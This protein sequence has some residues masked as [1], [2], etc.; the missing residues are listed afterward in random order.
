MSPLGKGIA[1]ASIFKCMNP[2]RRFLKDLLKGTLS[3]A[4]L[5]GLGSS[6]ATASKASAAPLCSR[7][8]DLSAKALGGRNA[9]YLHSSL[10]GQDLPDQLRAWT[11]KDYVLREKDPAQKRTI[12]LE[13]FL[14]RDLIIAPGHR[15]L[16]VSSSHPSA[17]PA[18][19]SQRVLLNAIT[20][21][22]GHL[23]FLDIW[24][25][26]HRILEA[27]RQGAET[28]KSLQEQGFIVDILIN[29]KPAGSF[30]AWKHILPA[31]A[32][33]PSWE[34]RAR[35]LS[36]KDV[37][38]SGEWSN[39]ELGSRTTLSQLVENEAQARQTK[40]G[41]F[42]GTFDPV[43]EN[44]IA[45]AKMGLSEFGL[46]KVILIPNALPQ[47]KKP[48]LL[49]YRQALLIERIKN[50]PG[51]DT[52]LFDTHYF[53]ERFGKHTLVEKIRQDLG[54]N[55]IFLIDGGDSFQKLMDLNQIRPTE[56]IH[57]I[58]SKRGDGITV[59]ARLQKKVF[60]SQKDFMEVSSSEIR[61]SFS[62]GKTPEEIK[63][64]RKSTEQVRAWGLYESDRPRLYSS[65]DLY[66]FMKASHPI[67]DLRFKGGEASSGLTFHHN[68][69]WQML[70]P[71]NKKMTYQVAYFKADTPESRRGK[72]RVEAEEAAF[73][74]NR[75]LNMDIVPPTVVIENVRAGGQVQA[76]GSLSFAVSGAE[77]L[78]T[79]ANLNSSLEQQLFFSDARILNVLL[80]NKDANDR[81]FLIGRH[82]STGKQAPFLIDFSQSFAKD[83]Y[84]S[85]TYYPVGHKG[86]IKVF[87]KSTLE[88]LKSLTAPLLRERL[89]H[90]LSEQDMNDIL[91]RRNG[92]VAYIEHLQQSP[93]DTPILY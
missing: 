27:F 74:L 36:E 17:K 46:D 57:Y 92:I 89:S 63:F 51:L 41:I 53:I 11:G 88:A 81:N 18:P 49:G 23:R 64:S 2:S 31:A 59:P 52:V 87:R 5:L 8:F 66:S 35:I 16:R 91:E 90:L 55:Q 15:V 78:L 47:H 20:S 77:K 82:W 72:N 12:V 25:G 3:A 19:G 32:T 34:A 30:S 85:M 42:F 83:Q 58:V 29:G 70:L 39:Y 44:H 45:V 84:L 86:E 14:L 73:L 67:S 43:H 65:E 1:F 40:L 50:E 79:E 33:H 28:I 4:V 80:H 62:E 24:D 6:L 93:Q 48:S 22:T 7:V 69:V 75:L 37:E 26:H 13:A 76:K 21:Q 54:S 9:E 68:D 60:L 71:G 56:V 10:W 38:V 61:Q